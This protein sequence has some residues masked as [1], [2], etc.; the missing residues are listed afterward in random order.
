[1]IMTNIAATS[2]SKILYSLNQRDGVVLV[3]VNGVSKKNT[4][5]RYRC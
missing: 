1:M 4:A 3:R 2:L 5:N